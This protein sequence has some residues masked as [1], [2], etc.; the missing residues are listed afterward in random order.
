VAISRELILEQIPDLNPDDQRLIDPKTGEAKFGDEFGDSVIAQ[1]LVVNPDR[2]K[3]LGS[4]TVSH[5][6]LN[7][8]LSPFSKQSR[9]LMTV[10]EPE[11]GFR[12]YRFGDSEPTVILDRQNLIAEGQK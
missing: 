4:L 2:K 3:I 5:P 1:A 7:L 6:K 9:I 8:K 10:G 11:T 12:P